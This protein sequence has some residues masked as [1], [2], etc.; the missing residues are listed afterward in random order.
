MTVDTIAYPRVWR[1][2][3]SG[4]VAISRG[5][6]PLL[7]GIVLFSRSAPILPLM[8]LRAFMILAV[9][10]WLAEWL[11]ERAFATA[12]DI[13]AE[14]LVLR[15]EGLRVEIPAAAIARIDPWVVPLPGCGLSLRLCS[16]RRFRYG[17]QVRDPVPLLNAIAEVV[18]TDAAQLAA[19]HPTMLYA[20]AKRRRPRWRWYHCLL[21]YPVFALLPTLP[22]FR[23]QQYVSYGGTFGQYYQQGFVPYAQHF[24]LYWMTVTLYLVLYSAVWRGLAEAIAL[25]SAWAAPS[26]ATRVRQAVE[27]GYRVFYYGGVPVLLIR[28]F[29]PW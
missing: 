3:A 12:I 6:L 4:L 20:D 9:A 24:V 27:T 18:G 17:M 10:P 5:S 8:L 1:L 11:I 25:G 16:G 14:A 26:R 22:L 19:R 15:R 7:L 2:V 21:Q 23:L 29:L 13:G 28:Y